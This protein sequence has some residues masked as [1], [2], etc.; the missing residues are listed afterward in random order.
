MIESCISGKTTGLDR[1]RESQAQI[2]RG[3][4]NKK[5][6]DCA[7]LLWEDFMYLANNREISS[8]RK[9]HMPYPRFTKVIINHV[10]S[11]DKTI[12]M[13]NMINLHT[14]CDDSLLEPV[15]KA[16]IVKRPA[17]KSTT[18]PTACVSIRDIPGVSASKKKAPAKADRTNGIEILSD[19]ALSEVAQLKEATNKSKKVFHIS[20]A[21]GSGDGTDFELV[22]P[23]EQ[24]R[25]K[26]GDS[27][28]DNDDLI[29]DDDDDD[30]ANDDDS[31][32]D[33][34][35][36]DSNNDGNSDVDDNEWTDLDDDDGNPSF[37]LKDYDGEENDKECESDDDYENVFEEEDNDLY[38]DVDVRSLG[39]EHEKKGKK[40]ECLKQS[41]YVP[42]D[43]AI[44][45]LILEN[46]PPA[47]DEVASMMNVKNCQEESSTQAPSL[48]TMPEMTIPTTSTIQAITIPPT[49]SMITPFPQLMTPSL[50]PTTIPTTTLIATLLDFSSLFG[51]DQRVS[52]LETELSQLK[53]AHQSAQLLE[54]VKSQLPT[55]VDDLL[56]TRIRYVT[57][58]SLDSYTKEF[59]KKA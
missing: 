35:K 26:S 49:I 3:M 27:E 22:A 17:K 5:N 43:F 8:A 9:E 55:M 30:N 10:I 15:K 4:Y 45:F 51:F 57:R 36:T 32:G 34:D 25:K 2:W 6:V 42:S 44:K 7:T 19:V 40:C 12:S 20:Q 31:K 24:Q 58:T 38:K 59:E 52:T 21:S 29:D 39:T 14:I 13:R 28:D 53:Q 48:F 50:A 23:D 37:T 11:K 54:Y 56:S 33:D 46:V 1:L 41:S 16:K 18:T 47:V